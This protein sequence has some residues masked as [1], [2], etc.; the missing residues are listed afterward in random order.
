MTNN[1]MKMLKP[2]HT[3]SHLDGFFGELFILYIL[4]LNLN[5]LFCSLNKFHQS[6]A[7]NIKFLQS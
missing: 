3:M 4:L 5:E 1:G 7:K 6:N 2:A